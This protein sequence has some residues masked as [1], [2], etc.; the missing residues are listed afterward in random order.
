M[1][2]FQ[3]NRG[4][5]KIVLNFINSYH[6][7]EHAFAMNWIFISRIQSQDCNSLFLTALFNLKKKQFHELALSQGTNLVDTKISFYCIAQ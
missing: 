5:Q 2:A 3:S 6:V 7:L 4:Q 1:F